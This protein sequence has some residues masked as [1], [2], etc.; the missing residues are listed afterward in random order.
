M[1]GKLFLYFWAYVQ[2]LWLVLYVVALPI[3]VVL[4]PPWQ[5]LLEDH[6]VPH[7]LVQN[8]IYRKVVFT[9]LRPCNFEKVFIQIVQ[10]L[11]VF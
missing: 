8:V 7:L 6:Q 4:P 2:L 1:L 3:D 9:N 10:E 11:K 5:G